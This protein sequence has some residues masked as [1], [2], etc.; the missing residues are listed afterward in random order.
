MSFIALLSGC[1]GNKT[2]ISESKS[3][4]F[5]ESSSESN[6]V[7]S[8]FVGDYP[9]NPIS[10]LTLSKDEIIN[11][12]SDLIFNTPNVSRSWEISGDIST[13]RSVSYNVTA[14]TTVYGTLV[15]DGIISRG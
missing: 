1:D 8:D 5:E 3:T 11:T 2:Q 10:L 6:T 4:S 14:Y 12:Y 7:F 15:A 9:E 13:N